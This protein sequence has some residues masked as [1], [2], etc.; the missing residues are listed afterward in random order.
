MGYAENLN[1]AV[2]FCEPYKS[3]QKGSIENANRLL[4]TQ[5]PKRTDIDKIEQ[6]E[7]DKIVDLL[8]DRP[9]KCLSYATPKEAFF[10]HFGTQPILAGSRA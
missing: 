1:A 10:K 7:I 6:N 9:M 4:R 8:N 5:F 3:Y 2:Y